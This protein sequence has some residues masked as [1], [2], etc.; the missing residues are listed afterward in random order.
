M[1]KSPANQ[2]PPHLE[3][4]MN[5]PDGNVKAARPENPEKAGEIGEKHPIPE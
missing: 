3:Q 4:N 5:N 1:S 2:G